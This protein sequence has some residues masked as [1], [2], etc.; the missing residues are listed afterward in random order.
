[1]GNVFAKS[2][3]RGLL[4]QN[5]PS[6]CDNIVF[7]GFFFN[8]NIKGDII[9]PGYV[10]HLAIGKRYID[11]NHVIDANGFLK[12]CIMPDLLDKEKSHYGDSSSN[13]DFQRFLTSNQLNTAYNQGYL[14]HLITDYLFYNRYLRDFSDE[15]YHDYNKLNGFLIKKY[16]IDIPPEIR[17]IVGDEKGKPKILTEDSICRF[18]EAIANIDLQKCKNLQ[19]YLQEYEI[20]KEKETEIE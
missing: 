14:L 4:K 3:R 9:M 12:G 2:E 20:D 17:E 1:M 13:P 10:I 18:I 8:K 7:G 19:Q 15:I 6:E 11:I 16:N 5:T